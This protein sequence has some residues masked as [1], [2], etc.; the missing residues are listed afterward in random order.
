MSGIEIQLMLIIA[1]LIGFAVFAAYSAVQFMR[2]RERDLAELIELRQYKER[3]ETDN[4]Q[5][6]A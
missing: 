5:N 3:T 6:S 2:V 4:Q 1:F